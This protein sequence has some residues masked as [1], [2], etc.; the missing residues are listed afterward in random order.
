MVRERGK[1]RG[2]EW[3]WEFKHAEDGSTTTN[4]EDNLILEKM[5]ILV[6]RI[7][8]RASAYVVFLL[9]ISL[10]SWLFAVVDLQA[11]LRVFHDGYSC[12]A[13]LVV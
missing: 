2:V 4:V 11:S 8:I 9:A 5:P 13:A 7:A 12:R 10:T 6:D 3:E 1:V